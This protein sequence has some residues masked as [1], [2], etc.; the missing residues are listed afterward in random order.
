[1]TTTAEYQAARIKALEA[2]NAYLVELV[3]A[4]AGKQP[5]PM[6]PWPVQAQT[7]GRPAPTPSEPVE[8]QSPARVGPARFAPRSFNPEDTLPAGIRFEDLA[9]DVWSTRQGGEVR[10]RSARY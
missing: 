5:M 6:P 9:T 4:L 1:M 8:T 3:L 2:T 7:A 10:R